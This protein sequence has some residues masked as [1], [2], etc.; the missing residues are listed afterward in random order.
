MLVKSWEKYP[1]SDST[2]II[3]IPSIGSVGQLAIDLLIHSL[4][5]TRIASFFSHHVLSVCGNDPFSGDKC[6]ELH[7]SLECIFNMIII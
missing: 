7:T 5:A 6:G 3:G 4:G 2:L 1:V